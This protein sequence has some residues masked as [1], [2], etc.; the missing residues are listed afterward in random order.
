MIGTTGLAQ[1]KPEGAPES[2]LCPHRT[3]SKDGRVVCLKIVEGDN[4][5]SPNVCRT[6]PIKAADC[7]H[8]RFSL[9][10]TSSSPLIVRFNGHTQIWDDEPPEVRFHQAGCAARVRPID[11]PRICSNCAEREPICEVETPATVPA[12]GTPK[13]RR[14]VSKGRVVPFPQPRAV[15]AST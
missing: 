10:L 5:V 9:R 3:V 1:R 13:P 12:T 15:S 8:L 2:S 7:I 6:C 4:K 14:A 11:H